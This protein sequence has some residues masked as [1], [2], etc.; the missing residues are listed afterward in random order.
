MDYVSL[1]EKGHPQMSGL[2]EEGNGKWI[3]LA[4]FEK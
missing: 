4:L 1:R 2:V 3:S